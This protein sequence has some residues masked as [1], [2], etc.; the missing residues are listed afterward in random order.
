VRA[1]EPLAVVAQAASTLELTS[2]AT[3][4]VPMPETETG[5]AAGSLFFGA[6]SDPEKVSRGAHDVRM[7]ESERS[8]A[9]SSPRAVI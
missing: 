3:T 2:S 4:D 7:V 1:S 8:K 5:T 6:T 9:S